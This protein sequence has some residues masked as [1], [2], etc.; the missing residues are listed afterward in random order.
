MN[1]SL[2]IYLFS[3]E[4]YMNYMMKNEKRTQRFKSQT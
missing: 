4:L 2:H 3:I 1:F